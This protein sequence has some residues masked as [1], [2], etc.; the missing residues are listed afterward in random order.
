MKGVA[1]RNRRGELDNS[2][3]AAR[4]QEVQARRSIIAPL[5]FAD[6]AVKAASRAQR[7]RSNTERLER[8]GRELHNRVRRPMNT[9]QTPCAFADCSVG[10]WK[11]PCSTEAATAWRERPLLWPRARSQ[12]RPDPVV[13]HATV[14]RLTASPAPSNWCGRQRAPPDALV[15]QI[16]APIEVGAKHPR[17]KLQSHQQQRALNWMLGRGNTPHCPLFPS[18]FP[19][20]RRRRR[21]EHRR[22]AYGSSNCTRDPVVIGP[23]SEAQLNGHD[24]GYGRRDLG[25]DNG[26][27]KRSV[28]NP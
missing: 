7:G 28:S 23:R 24:E 16:A 1:D 19:L 8:A 5:R 12:T 15:Q 25:A 9:T 22:R 11:S 14:L 21:S 4:R 17:A 27:D 18:L 3:V 2:A 6:R 10:L 26:S 13:A 20:L